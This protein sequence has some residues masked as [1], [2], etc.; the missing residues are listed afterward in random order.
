MV[1]QHRRICSECRRRRTVW[2]VRGDPSGAWVC[3][4]CESLVFARLRAV[5]G[6]EGDKIEDMLS[7]FDPPATTPK[8]E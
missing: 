4:D 5:P 3:G 8:G 7:R 6:F 2:Q 1:E